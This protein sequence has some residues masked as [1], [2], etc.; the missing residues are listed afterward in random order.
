MAKIL[1]VDDEE[2]IRNICLRVL[3]QASHDVT[4]AEDGQSALN[5][6]A[7]QDFDLF[8]IDVKMPGI[9]GIAV[10]NAVRERW[11]RAPIIIMSGVGDLEG[12]GQ[13]ISELACVLL[14]KPFR[15][16]ELREM[17]KRCLEECKR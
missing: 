1:V 4:Q 15:L 2:V 11:P 5:K 17:V 3:A 8:L 13:A 9:D 7:E 6:M 12:K 14:P 10:A 16:E